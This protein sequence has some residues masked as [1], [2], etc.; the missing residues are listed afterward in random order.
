[1]TWYNTEH[2]QSGSA[3]FTP[4]QVFTGQYH[5]IAQTKQLALDFGYQNHPERFVKGRPIVPM[6]PKTVAINPITP[7][8]DGEY[9]DDR[10]IF[11]TLT[12]AGYVK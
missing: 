7:S 1:V 12:E 5:K 9:V 8:N 6:P 2:R 4:E 10:V 3:S 11:P